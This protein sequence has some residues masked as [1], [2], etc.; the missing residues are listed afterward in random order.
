MTS[1]TP[2]ALY[3]DGDIR[4]LLLM[5]EQVRLLPTEG[6][7]ADFTVERKDDILFLHLAAG[8][9]PTFMIEGE[10]EPELRMAHS[11]LILAVTKSG[12]VPLKLRASFTFPGDAVLAGR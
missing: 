12:L 1:P 8:K 3:V 2:V 10:C 5:P 9:A 7:M 6:E 11:I 4:S